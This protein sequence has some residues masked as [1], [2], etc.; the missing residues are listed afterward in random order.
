MFESL[1]FYYHQCSLTFF[2][3]FHFARE[4]RGFTLPIFWC[5]MMTSTIFFLGDIE[6]EGR[7]PEN[8]TFQF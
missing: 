5:F 1:C 4:L 7:K 3:L 2:L 8:N 6:K